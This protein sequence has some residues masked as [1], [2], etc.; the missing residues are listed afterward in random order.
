MD[1]PV[2]ILENFLSSEHCKYLIDTYKDKV[3]QSKVVINTSDGKTISDTHNSRTSSTCFIPKTDTVITELRNKVANMLEV[4][5]KNIEGIQ[6]LKYAKNER[7][8]WHHDFLKG[9]NVTNQRVNT[10]IVYL[11]DLEES[12]GGATGFFYYKMK[13]TP[14]E[15]RAVWFKNCDNEG[16]L[17]NESLHAGEEILT[18]TVKYALNIWVRQ[19]PL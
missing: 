11:N 9:E 10:L 7:Y 5:S 13:V 8:L 19:K 15:G 2:K 17:I 3:I 14:K 1:P 12:D 4:D 6:F 16:K 18:D